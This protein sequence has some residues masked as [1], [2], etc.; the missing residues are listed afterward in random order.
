MHF[1]ESSLS[2]TPSRTRTSPRQADAWSLPPPGDGYL[3]VRINRNTLI[4]VLVSLLVHALLLFFLPNLLPL[5]PPARAP[6]QDLVIRLDTVKLPPPA[7]KPEPE[8]QTP[9][10]PEPEPAPKPKP[11]PKPRPERK[12][13]PKTPPVIATEQAQPEQLAAP[14]SEP[15]PVKE[16]APEPPASQPSAEAAPTDMMSFVNAARARRRLAMDDIARQNAEAVARERGPTAEE[17]RDAIIKR[18]LQTEGTNGLFQILGMNDRSARFS[19]RGWTDNYSSAKR[20][21]IE[22]RAEPG[23]DI[24]RAVVRRMISLIREYYKGDFNWDSHRL[25]RVVILS[26]RLEDNAGLEDFLIEEFFGAQGMAFE[27]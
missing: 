18:N 22:V 14:E 8:V 26:A 4:A 27:R 6:Q 9:P 15:E 5:T 25:G 7:P 1:G 24:Q 3:H 2:S 10:A 13:Q 23:V 21:I 12:P 11:K 16:P 20:Q 19:F 17:R